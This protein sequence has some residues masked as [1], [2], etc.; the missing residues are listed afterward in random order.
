[1]YFDLRKAFDSVPHRPLL[2]KLLDI[3]LCPYIVQWLGSYLTKRSQLVVV[4]GTSSP[5]LPVVSGVPQG[6][7]L[8]PLLFLIFI[9]DVIT[10]VSAGSSL[11]LFADDIA[12]YRPISN[13]ADFS[14][15]QCDISAIALWIRN[16]FLALQPSKCCAMLLTHK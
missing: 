5:I 4:E 9:N 11:S 8:G 16:N 15:I 10:Q 6:S 2:Q 3:Q 1:M 14:I 12:L 7:V 13:I